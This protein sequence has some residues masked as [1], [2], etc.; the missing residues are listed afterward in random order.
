MTREGCGGGV[1]GVHG[2]RGNGNGNQSEN[3]VDISNPTRFY[4]KE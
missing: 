2:G 4:G 3:Y 1:Q